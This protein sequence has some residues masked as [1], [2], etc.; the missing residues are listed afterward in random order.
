MERAGVKPPEYVSY[1]R[2][3][4]PKLEN[5][6]W[7][8]ALPLSEMEQFDLDRLVAVL[9]EPLSRLRDL[10][11]SGHVN[12]DE[13]LAVK[14]VYPDVYQAVVDACVRDMIEAGPPFE[15]WAQLTL[16][17]LFLKPAPEMYAEAQQ[18]EQQQGG[19]PGPTGL[20]GAI[21]TPSDRREPAIRE[22]TRR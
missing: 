2:Q 1:V 12:T 11:V 5:D 13:V 9:T 18:P 3:H 15:R 19:A 17:V 14:D 7:G 21:A 22:L 16:G 6:E 4:G 20:P 10:V 8:Q